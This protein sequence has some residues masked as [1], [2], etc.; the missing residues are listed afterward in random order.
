MKLHP[1]LAATF[2][3]ITNLHD[4]LR[5]KGC[6]GCNLGL[7]KELV[8]PS[9]F[10]GNPESK[11]LM[12]GEAPG[13][14]EDR[15]GRVF[16]GPAGKELDKLFLRHG[17]FVTNRDFLLT[18]CV[19]CR[20]IAPPGLGK[21]NLTPSRNQVSACKPFVDRIIETIQ[22]KLIVL[23]GKIA[24]ASIL[25]LP[26]DIKITQ[27]A[28]QINLSSKYDGIILYPMFHPSFLLRLKF[29]QGARET[30]YLKEAINHI[31][32]LRRIYN[33]LT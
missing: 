14:D 18:N 27:Y 8:G 4:S 28:G 10:R 13:K 30:S 23:L 19:F 20:P 17:D 7:Q 29:S 22:P 15:I 25:D 9:V 26:S 12:I 11:F 21:Q 16:T 31:Q 6:K 33:E 2:P 24:T 5:S 3:S 32:D 1:S